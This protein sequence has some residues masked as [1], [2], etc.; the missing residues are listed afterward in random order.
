MRRAL[1]VRLDVGHQEP[2]EPLDVGR[3][4]LL[5]RSALADAVRQ[6]PSVQGEL[7]DEECSAAAQ[8]PALGRCWLLAQAVA[9]E[10]MAIE[11]E[12][13][14]ASESPKAQ[15]SQEPSPREAASCLHLAAPVG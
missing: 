2:W 8:P 1:R 9:A 12:P 10:R 6:V 14:H 3:S 15:V 13:S 4:A 5:E 11:L 7:T